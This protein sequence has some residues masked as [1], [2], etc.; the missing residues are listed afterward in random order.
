L[1]GFDMGLVRPP[2]VFYAFDLLRLNVTRQM[3]EVLQGLREKARRQHKE[4]SWGARPKNQM[5]NAG[6][7]LSL[8]G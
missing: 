6:V 4:L 7:T 2:I 3:E 5:A 8:M 1:Q